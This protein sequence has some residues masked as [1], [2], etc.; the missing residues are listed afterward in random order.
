MEVKLDSQF[1]DKYFAKIDLGVREPDGAEDEQTLQ[2]AIGKLWS[3]SLE[4]EFES[5][6]W[7]SALIGTKPRSAIIEKTE[8]TR[9]HAGDTL[10][11]SKAAA[12]SA[13]GSLGTTHTLVGNEENLDLSQV[14]FV[15]SRVGNA[16][17]WRTK[18]GEHTV[19]FDLRNEVKDLL[20][21]WAA[22]AVEKRLIAACDLCSAANTLFAGTAASKAGVTATDVMQATDLL[23][24]YVCLLD[25]G[26]KG[27]QELGGY[28][29]LIMHPRQWFDLSM[30]P[31]FMST[32]AAASAVKAYDIEGFVGSYSNFR[33]FTSNLCHSQDSGGSPGEMVY[34]MYALGARSLGLGWEQRWSWLEKGDIDYGETKGIGTDAWFEAKILN[35][36]YLYRLQSAGTNPRT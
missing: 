2:G 11:I 1:F 20:A 30:D 17:K 34:S 15:P 9:K 5:D 31:V 18:S 10:H 6:L 27:I 25:S 36:K 7:L 32:V 22:E 4:K 23:R 35:Q 28:F 8:L 19:S 14:S 26:A 33:I 12:L 16:V 3:F 13:E 24:L 29:A 21:A